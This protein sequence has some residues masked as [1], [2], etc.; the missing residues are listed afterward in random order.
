MRIA[1]LVWLENLSTPILR[2]QV[3][4]VLKD[5]GRISPQDRIFLCAFQPVYRMLLRGQSLAR[6]RRELEASGIRMIVIPCF[7]LPQIDLFRARW[8]LLPLVFLKS[9]PALLLF[10]LLC[11]IDVLHC[12]SYPVTWAAVAVRRITGVKVIFD[13][14]A[15]FPE[16]SLVAGFWSDTSLTHRMWKRIERRLLAE[17]DVTVAILE[18]YV[19][20]FRGIEPAAAVR[21]IPNNVDTAAFARDEASRKSLRQASGIGDDVVVFC[22]S[23]TLGTHWHKVEPYL[24]FIRHL[25]G[26]AAPHV[27]IFVSPEAEALR[28]KIAAANGPGADEY[29]LVSASFEDVP[30]HLS[31]ADFGVVLMEGYTSISMGIKTVEYLSMGL[32]VITNLNVAGAAEVVGGFG[33]GLVIRDL[34]NPDIGA[35][36]DLIAR[37]PDVARAC[38]SL[39]IDRF[40]TERVAAQYASL[41]AEVGAHSG[42]PVKG[43]AK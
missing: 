15:A 23:G 6:I 9:F 10:T 27:F 39:A 19:A 34:D 7:T 31:M 37:R 8:Y 3:I 17:A 18:T 4:D 16:E 1:Y 24:K 2:S 29:I 33:V 21:I 25:R 28:T 38:R 14:R 13:P 30:A 42:T 43:M 26:L 41:Y 32:P 20:H 12:R 5:I 35:I 36:Q 11:R 40:A 22:Y